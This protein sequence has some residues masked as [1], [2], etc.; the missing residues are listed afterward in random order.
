MASKVSQVKIILSTAAK[1]LLYV[2]AGIVVGGYEPALAPIA[3]SFLSGVR[4]RV[5]VR[6]EDSKT[7]GFAYD[8]LKK[9]GSEGLKESTLQTKNSLTFEIKAIIDKLKSGNYNEATIRKAIEILK[10]HKD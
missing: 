8:I 5:N 4:K 9:P 7:N 2:A 1:K 3:L 6:I 10:T